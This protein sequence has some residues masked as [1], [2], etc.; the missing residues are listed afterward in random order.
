MRGQGQIKADGA[1]EKNWSIFKC[2]N[3]AKLWV[4][5]VI[6]GETVLVAMNSAYLYIVA[7]DEERD[8]LSDDELLDL[9]GT[10]MQEMEAVEAQLCTERMM[11]LLFHDL[12]QKSLIYPTKT[13]VQKGYKWL[14]DE[15]AALGIAV[16]K[17]RALV[18]DNIVLNFAMS[19]RQDHY[20]LFTA[21]L[22]NTGVP[23][24]MGDEVVEG[25]LEAQRIVNG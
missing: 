1:D 6:P 12:I 11:R 19:A 3:D 17:D 22:V 13:T 14:R 16:P 5:R 18:L 9:V 23:E 20:R 8:D 2:A 10:R 24:M 25:L 7:T 21:L 15:C 4:K